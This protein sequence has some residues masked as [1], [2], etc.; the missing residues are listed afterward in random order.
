MPS[1][2]R[3][4]GA[5]WRMLNQRLLANFRIMD[6]ARKAAAGQGGS[7][8][9]AIAGTARSKGRRI[10]AAG[11]VAVVFVMMLPAGTGAHPHHEE[12]V[13]KLDRGVSE[14]VSLSSS[15]QEGNG[16]SGIG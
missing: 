12:Y 9:S 8:A 4:G 3:W 14:R 1:R 16:P 10:R 2:S 5:L 11:S 7:M 15:G 13:N 6:Q